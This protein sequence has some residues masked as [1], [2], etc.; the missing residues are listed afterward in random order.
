V[1]VIG[2][3]FI[4]RLNAKL[5]AHLPA[6]AAGHAAAQVTSLTPQSL[7]H[8][9]AGLREVVKVAFAQALPPIYLYLVP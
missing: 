2:A 1:A 9:P 5:A 6:A 3:L 8:L 4:H 7:S